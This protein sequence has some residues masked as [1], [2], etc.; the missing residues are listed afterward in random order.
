[1]R[2]VRG[3]RLTQG[4]PSKLDIFVLATQKGLRNKLVQFSAPFF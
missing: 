2:V 3:L 4:L 1:L